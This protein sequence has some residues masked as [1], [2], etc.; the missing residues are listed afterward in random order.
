M[1]GTNAEELKRIRDENDFEMLKEIF[2]LCN[3]AFH[4]VLIEIREDNYKGQK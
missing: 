4:Q 3:F 1:K 2:H